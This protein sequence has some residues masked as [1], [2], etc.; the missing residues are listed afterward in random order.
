MDIFYIGDSG[1]SKAGRT[2]YFFGSRWTKSWWCA[3]VG[4]KVV[5]VV[6][7]RVISV[8]ARR[9][10]KCGA[11]RCLLAQNW[12]ER[13]GSCNENGWRCNE[14]N[15]AM[16]KDLSEVVTRESEVAVS[17]FYWIEYNGKNNSFWGGWLCRDWAFLFCWRFVALSIHKA[18]L[19]LPRTPQGIKLGFQHFYSIEK[20]MPQRKIP[21][22]EK[23]T[24]T[25]LPPSSSSSFLLPTPH[26]LPL[27]ALAYIASTDLNAARLNAPLS[28]R[29]TMVSHP[30]IINIRS[31]SLA[32]PEFNAQLWRSSCSFSAFGILFTRL[33]Q[34]R[35]QVFHYSH[36][37]MIKNRQSF[38]LANGSLTPNAHTYD[39]WQVHRS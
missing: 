11:S 4:V 30:P 19:V 2:H 24:L 36:R 25:D 32:A 10:P 28:R 29:G 6:V 21:W 8:Y 14:R 12:S 7:G 13:G 35:R 37:N 34:Y 39:M 38:V 33:R 16:W 15:H 5:V 23:R 27:A 20:Q 18:E 31:G 3:V 17:A 22:F 9:E 26:S 1:W